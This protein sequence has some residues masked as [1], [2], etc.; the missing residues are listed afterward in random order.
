MRLEKGSD[1]QDYILSAFGGG[2]GQHAC[3]VAKALNMRKVYLH[4]MA[5][6]LSA[7]GIG[8]A[9]QRWLAEDLPCYFWGDLDFAGIGILK[10]LRHSLPGLS[11]WQPGYHPMLAMLENGEGHT[12]QQA[13]KTGQ[14]DPVATGC[15]LCDRVLLPALRQSQ[16]FID[17]ESVTLF[18]LNTPS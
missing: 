7:Y 9:D 12:A 4:P 5:G 8:I 13:R 1:V 16:R 3:A 2:G 11:A 17:Q 18:A 10:A 15:P 14:T 6:V